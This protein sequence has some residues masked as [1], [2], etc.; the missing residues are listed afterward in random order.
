M[1]LLGIINVLGHPGFNSLCCHTQIVVTGVSVPS[2]HPA[3]VTN[4]LSSAFARHRTVGLPADLTVA[5]WWCWF[6]ILLFC[7]SIFA[8]DLTCH[9]RNGPIRDLNHVGV[10]NWG[11]NV[12]FGKITNN[13][14]EFSSDVGFNIFAE[15]RVKIDAISGPGSVLLLTAGI[16]LIEPQLVVVTS[17]F[18]GL[19]IR[20]NC[21]LEY[22]LIGGELAKFVID[23]PRQIFYDGRRM[24]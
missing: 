22:F 18:Q 7:S 6:N 1:E 9:V 21:I 2:L 11:K 3:V 8:R 13:F 23:S 10:D 17:F 5:S 20:R 14:E 15:G 19:L 24:I 16:N 12:I 4:I